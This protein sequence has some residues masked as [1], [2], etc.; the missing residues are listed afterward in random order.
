M[1]PNTFAAWA[2]S[3]AAVAFIACTVAYVRAY[4]ETWRRI[5][6]LDAAC[7]E[8][9]LLARDAFRF[10]A[11]GNGA[12]DNIVAFPPVKQMPADIPVIA[13]DQE[14]TAPET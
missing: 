2:L 10:G 3:F 6:L 5:E 13:N 11:D 9:F 14:D 12:A 8:V 1:H 4:R 7:N